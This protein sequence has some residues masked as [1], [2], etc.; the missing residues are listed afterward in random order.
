MIPEDAVQR[1]AVI[2][3]PENAA[4]QITEV[5]ALN[6]R[7]ADCRARMESLRTLHRILA[8]LNCLAGLL[9]TG[10]AQVMERRGNWSMVSVVLYLGIVIFL[11]VWQLA[12]PENPLIFAGASLLPALA[13]PHFLWL[14]V[15]D[16][17]LFFLHRHMV[18]KL[19]GMAGYPDF[20]PVKI[21]YAPEHTDPTR[22]EI[23]Q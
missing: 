7:L 23:P 13:A 10:F 22:K 1:G 16:L 6:R 19:R 9:I 17:L 14:T 12:R 20:R 5:H 11:T 2:V 15:A 21:H 8:G 4:E 3:E 18:R